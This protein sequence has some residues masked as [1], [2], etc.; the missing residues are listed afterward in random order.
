MMKFPAVNFAKRIIFAFIALCLS[1]SVWAKGPVPP[2]VIAAHDLPVEARE[3]LA[4]IKRGGPF[5]Y[6]RDGVIFKNYEGV[7]PKQKRGYYHEYTVKTP[8]VRHRGARRI[9][10]GGMPQQGQEYFYTDD[11][12]VS[13]KRIRE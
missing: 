8:G 13:F 1:L 9:I 11:H 3:T 10:S 6:A 5:P 2:G 12:Y 7:L 4:L